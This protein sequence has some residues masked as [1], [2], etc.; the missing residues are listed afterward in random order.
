[1]TTRS[2]LEASL[3]VH[4]ADVLELILTAAG[5]SPQGAETPSELAAR[6]V[7]AMW[8]A[9]STPLGY[10][11][12]RAS[13]EDIIWHIARR[14]RVSDR[15]DRSADAYEQSQQLTTALLGTLPDEAIG[16][17][18]LDPD[19]QRR[20]GASWLPTLLW[21]GSAG[22]TWAARWGSGKVLDWMKT[23]VGR[24]LPLLP[25][26]GPYVRFL[27]G[28]SGT[29]HAV[30]GPLGVALSVLTFNEA[31]GANY[32]RLVP[33]V[34]SV[35][36]LRPRSVDDAQIIDFPSRPA[37]SDRAPSSRDTEDDSVLETAPARGMTDPS[38]D[39]SAAESLSSSQTDDTDE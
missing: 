32:R 3:S 2:E 10:L 9:Y 27:Q 19:T 17:A 26:I 28:A 30:A 14:L 18:E 13:F 38:D 5:V 23:P 12:D 25:A 36:A 1:M 39:R 29:V 16:V 7:D 37:P 8:W 15:V 24:V 20:L 34:L 11:A 33:L 35:G 31:L 21:G 22:T 6:I 4:D